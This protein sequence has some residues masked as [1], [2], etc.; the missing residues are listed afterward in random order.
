MRVKR[1]LCCG[2]SVLALAGFG[3]SG[4]LPGVLPAD[5]EASGVVRAYAAS[6]SVDTS[7]VYFQDAKQKTYN[8]NGKA[9]TFSGTAQPGAKVLVEVFRA[10]GTDS[11]D[12]LFHTFKY[13]AA[14]YADSST[15]A[16]SLKVP[17]K[18]LLVNYVVRVLE[19]VPVDPSAE[20]YQT[21]PVYYSCATLAAV[22]SNTT[23]KYTGAYTATRVKWKFTLKN[24]HKGDT[25][26]FKYKKK[27]YTK[28]IKKNKKKLIYKVA[29]PNHHGAKFTMKLVSKYKQ[30][31]LKQTGTF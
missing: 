24:V 29:T 4:P 5:V 30:T 17:A 21:T 13:A 15:G 28:K 8:Y 2:L 7:L 20:L 31:L 12:E 14:A 3:V 18:Y 1:M 11:T 25:F 22:K 16:F 19:E 10:S 26:T 23:G 9:R 6:G 27:T